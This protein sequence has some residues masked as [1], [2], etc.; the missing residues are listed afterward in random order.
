M[1]ISCI[2]NSAEPVSTDKEDTTSPSMPSLPVNSA[3]VAADSFTTQPITATAHLYTHV[4]I[5]RGQEK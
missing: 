5:S 3:T 4:N 2:A 1:G